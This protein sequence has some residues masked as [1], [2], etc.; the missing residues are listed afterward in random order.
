MSAAGFKPPRGLAMVQSMRTGG[1]TNTLWLIGA[2]CAARALSG[3]GRKSGLDLPPSAAAS[4]PASAAAATEPQQEAH[5]LTSPLAKP[6]KPQPRV[7]PNRTL[8]IDVLLN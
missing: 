8:P 3:C 4:A 1:R 7:V 5:S 2:V 6:P